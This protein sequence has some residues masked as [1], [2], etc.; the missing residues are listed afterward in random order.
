M[1]SST[2]DHV[3]VNLY[4]VLDD[5]TPRE[6]GVAFSGGVDSTL[7]AKVCT[8]L[9]KRVTLCTI[10]FASRRDIAIAQRVA[11][12]LALPLCHNEVP[13]DALEASVKRVVSL[14]DFTRLARL[15]NSVCFYHVFELQTVFSAN[16]LDELFCGYHAYRRQFLSGEPAVTNLMQ[17]LVATARADK[18]EIDKLAATFGID[19]RCPFLS[20][21][22]VNYAMTIPLPLKIRGEDDTM[23]KHVLR[24]VAKAVGI[25][26]AAAYRPKKAFQYSSGVHRALKRLTKQRGYT[27]SRATQAGYRSALKAYLAHLSG[28]ND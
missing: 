17:R 27:R 10:G 18:A 25:P 22:F 13:L 23:R 5:V 11:A 8:D 19:Y 9:G 15:E 24:T 16:G 2:A 3:R 14:I 7:L 26:D 1:P 28:R 20:A 6:L 12:M 4:R 21:G